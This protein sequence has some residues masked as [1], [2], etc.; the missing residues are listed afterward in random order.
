MEVQYR[1]NLKSNY[2]VMKNP[3]VKVNDYR[4]KMLMKNDIQG[5]LKFY[6]SC[7]DGEIEFSYRISSK[8]SLMDLLGKQKL[9][10]E[11]MINIMKGI[12]SIAEKAH[13]YLLKIDDVLLE[14]ELIYIDYSCSELW[15][16]YYPNSGNHFNEAIKNLVQ[17]LILITE[18]GD[19]NAV[20]LIYGIYD[21][22]EKA[23]FLI[24]DI[25][26]F[27][28][29]HDKNNFH[30]EAD[31]ITYDREKTENEQYNLNMVRE[32]NDIMEIINEGITENEISMI[33]KE[34][35][36]I[37]KISKLFGIF[38][39]LKFKKNEKNE[40]GFN[41]IHKGSEFEHDSVRT[42][43]MKE[44]YNQY[45]Y[46]ETVLLSDVD[47]DLKRI[48]ISAD[49]QNK[50]EINNFPFIIGKLKERVDYVLDD[51]SVSRMHLKL[52]IDENN[53]FLVEDLNSKN[54]TYINDIRLRPYE[55]RYIETGDKIRIAAFDYIFR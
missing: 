7:V 55:K 8:Q 28:S 51:K 49:G 15:F 25:E 12:V 38:N 34:N 16:C 26:L 33:I 45:E 3:N 27:M 19:S 30:G 17:K 53:R 54:G 6:V 18:H 21:I 2:V 29:S 41:N 11:E 46:E 36:I 4:L 42:H 5:F 23:D 1:N 37:K 13:R 39:I 14:P 20:R 40:I 43:K 22:C 9:R 32:E 44:E 10:Y 24:S 35:G 48:L 50:I 52:A 31:S 47:L